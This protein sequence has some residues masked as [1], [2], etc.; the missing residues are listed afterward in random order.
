MPN[1]RYEVHPRNG[2]WIVD[3]YADVKGDGSFSEQRAAWIT[4]GRSRKHADEIAAALNVAL[5]V[6]ARSDW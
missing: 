2:R 6:G 1:L 3:L 4:D 5:G